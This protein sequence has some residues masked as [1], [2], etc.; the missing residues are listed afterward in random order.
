LLTA[1][2]DRLAEAGLIRRPKAFG[3][4]G[5]QAWALMSLDRWMT[6][7]GAL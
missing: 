4:T 5:E 1:A 7:S 3:F 6:T 2:L